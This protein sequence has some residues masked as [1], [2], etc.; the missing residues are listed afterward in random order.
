MPKWLKCK[1]TKGMFSDEFTV[2]VRT[3]SGENVAVFV[4]KDYAQEGNGRVKV[5][6]SE[7][8]GHAIA[9]LPDANQSVID[10]DASEL[11]PA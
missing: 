10:V 2:I 11:T 3:L 8:L 5:K 6:A 9:V 1:I 7:A 4:P